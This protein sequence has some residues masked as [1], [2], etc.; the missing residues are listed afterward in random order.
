MLLMLI[1][2]WV[3]M[4]FFTEAV[5]LLEFY[6]QSCFIISDMMFAWLFGDVHVTNWIVDAY[7]Y[8]D[9]YWNY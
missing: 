4:V 8:M 5:S 9:G 2:A 6:V 1:N 7:W 3:A